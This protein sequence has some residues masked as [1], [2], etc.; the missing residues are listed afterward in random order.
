MKKRTIRILFWTFFIIG[1]MVGYLIPGDFRSLMKKAQEKT[2]ESEIFDI[3]K[4]MG[5]LDLQNDYFKYSV[6]AK[7]EAG[8]IELLRFDNSIPKHVHPKES[9]FAYVYKGRARGIIGGALVE[10]GPGQMISIPA[11][12]SHSF[13]RIGDSPVEIILFSTPPFDPKDT[14]LLDK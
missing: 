14:V 4:R 11:G 13:E 1:I 6:L 2:Q 9:H 8:S 10:V 7:N 12:V 5:Q 3:A